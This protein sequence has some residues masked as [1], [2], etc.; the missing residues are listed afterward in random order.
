[1]QK[2]L[3][4]IEEKISHLEYQMRDMPNYLAEPHKLALEVWHTVRAMA[5]ERIREDLENSDTRQGFG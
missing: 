5:Q 3:K 4:Q 1:M 2:L